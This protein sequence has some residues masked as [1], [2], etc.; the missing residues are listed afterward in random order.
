MTKHARTSSQSRALRL[1]AAAVVS[2]AIT[3]GLFT[4]AEMPSATA[5]QN[6][7]RMEISCSRLFAPTRWEA[8]KRCPSTER[9]DMVSRSATCLFESPCAASA[10]ISLCRAVNGRGVVA[11][12]SAGVWAPWHSAASRWAVADALNAAPR[13][14]AF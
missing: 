8:R 10:M 2:A 12:R 5:A 9:V 13:K 7:R 4:G 3:A 11:A 1:T 14:L 6:P